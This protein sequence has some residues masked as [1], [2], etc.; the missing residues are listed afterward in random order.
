MSPRLTRIEARVSL[1]P[2]S[3]SSLSDTPCWMETIS[4]INM[5]FGC[6]FSIFFLVFSEAARL[7]LHNPSKSYEFI[8]FCAKNRS[9]HIFWTDE[10]KALSF[11]NGALA[12]D[13]PQC[14]TSI[15]LSNAYLFMTQRPKKS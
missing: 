13:V 14:D 5:E 6:L 11:Q 8:Y 7:T 3:Q 12:F 4:V 10:N 2:L 15:Q 9:N 1:A